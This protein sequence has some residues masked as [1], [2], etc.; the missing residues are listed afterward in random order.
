M[1]GAP[2]GPSFEPLTPGGEAG[3]VRSLGCDETPLLTAATSEREEPG[4]AKHRVSSLSPG[5]PP[6]PPNT[7][8]L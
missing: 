4:R 3:S 8:G 5:R 2:A 1:G 7:P 6:A